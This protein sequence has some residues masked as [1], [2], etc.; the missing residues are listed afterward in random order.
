MIS[1]E[2]WSGIDGVIFDLDG[3]ITDT[4]QVHAK[5]WQELFDGF[6]SEC[7]DH[8]DGQGP[9]ADAL[10]P[11]D[12]DGEYRAFVDGKPSQEGVISLLEARGISMPIGRRDDPAG[13]ATVY[14]MARRKNES[15]RRHVDA[16]GVD[17]Y[18]STIR[19][20]RRL[21]ATGRRVGVASSS[22]T[23]ARVLDSAGIADLFEVLIDGKYLDD[24]GIEGKPAPD[25]FCTAARKLDVAPS[26]A[27]V[28]EDA[29]SGVEAAVAGEFRLVIGVNRTGH[30]DGLR[31]SGATM[32]VDDLGEIEPPAPRVDL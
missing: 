20:V 24:H 11:F 12:L 22:H 6:F 19:L 13:S 8:H 3:V 15:F 27:A 21:L 28:I 4:A 25:I 31:R 9:E 1:S 16:N 26:A 17:V 5:A 30:A 10:R 29:I 2:I 32:V 23:A 7:G 18:P 14:G